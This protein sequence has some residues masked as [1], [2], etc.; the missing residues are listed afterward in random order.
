[1]PAQREPLTCRFVV[2]A[3]NGIEPRYQLGKS[4]AL[5]ARHLPIP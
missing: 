5:P 3:D 2:G 1:M 4:V